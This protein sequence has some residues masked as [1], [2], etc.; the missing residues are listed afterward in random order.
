MKLMHELNQRFAQGKAEGRAEMN[1]E[2]RLLSERLVADGRES[3]AI[4][5][6]GDPARRVRELDGYGIVAHPD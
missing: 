1:E 2:N 5:I 4:E 3:E 6:L